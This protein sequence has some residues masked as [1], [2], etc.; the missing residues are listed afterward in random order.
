MEL[1]AV[2]NREGFIALL[3][4]LLRQSGGLLD[5][6][7]LAKLCGLSRH[8][9]KS[10]AHALEAAHA[11][12]LLAPFSGNGTREIVDRPKCYGFDTGFVCHQR[13]WDSIRAD[14]RGI[15]WEHL[16]LDTLQTSFD[17]STLHYW[18]DKSQREID[19]VVQA[20]FDEVD[21]YEFK[22]SPAE[23][24]GKSLSA[25]HSLYPHENNYLVCP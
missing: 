6:T 24:S 23:F 3:K 13:G 12:H 20:G 14:D 9:V 16:V 15:L 7:K 5:Y 19:F 8:T 21:V 1:F 25:F 11:I 10:Y 17:Q 2:G 22:I 18:R 4:L